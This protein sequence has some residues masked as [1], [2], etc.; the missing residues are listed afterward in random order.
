MAGFSPFLLTRAI[1]F[2][3]LNLNWLNC[4][5][6]NQIWMR[7]FKIVSLDK[8]PLSS[9]KPHQGSSQE[10]DALSPFHFQI[11]FHPRLHVLP[12]YSPQLGSSCT[13]ETL[14]IMEGHLPSAF[15]PFSLSDFL[16]IGG[17]KIEAVTV[18]GHCFLSARTA[19]GSI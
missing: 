18:S 17:G 7:L 12:H 1:C 14:C 3:I 16:G 19:L 11:I 8:I 5:T 2:P 15:D 13:E 6:C 10:E 4:F 9:A